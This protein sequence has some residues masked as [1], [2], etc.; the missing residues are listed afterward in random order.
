MK[1]C[2]V[3]GSRANYS[4]IKSAMRAI[5]DHPKL[6]LQTVACASAIID[7][8]GRVVDHIRSDGFKVDDEVYM[9]VEEKIHLLWLNQLG[10]V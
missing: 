5:Q 2:I 9:I 4:S 6:E 3:V 10:S 8:Y 7:R 1:I